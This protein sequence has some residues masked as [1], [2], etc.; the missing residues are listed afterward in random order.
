[1]D[2]LASSFI[3]HKR[4]L[5]EYVLSR[6]GFPSV[7][8][9][10]YAHS[11]IHYQAQISKNTYR[12]TETLQSAELTRHSKPVPLPGAISLYYKSYD[13]FLNSRISL[14]ENVMPFYWLLNVFK[15]FSLVKFKICYFREIAHFSVS[16][17]T[18]VHMH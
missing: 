13:F 11:Q 16:R 6:F 15:A 9:Q 14:V 8:F 17:S 4:I 1:M 18:T 5:S 2:H 12:L 10:S 7:A 3:I